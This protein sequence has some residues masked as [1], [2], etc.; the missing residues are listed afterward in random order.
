MG[1]DGAREQQLLYQG[2]GVARSEGLPWVE[3]WKNT[4]MM[5]TTVNI[6]PASEEAGCHFR[7]Q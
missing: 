6:L 5:R 1:G 2:G 4:K 7:E 3:T